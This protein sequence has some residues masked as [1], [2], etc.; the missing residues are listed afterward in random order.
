MALNS[1][2]TLNKNDWEFVIKLTR[3]AHVHVLSHQVSLYFNKN[4]QDLGTNQETPLQFPANWSLQYI[5]IQPSKYEDNHV[6]TMT[7]QVFNA[8][9][10]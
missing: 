3:I 2:C 1:A 6:V 8:P 5:G 7:W 4:Q 10:K 9:V